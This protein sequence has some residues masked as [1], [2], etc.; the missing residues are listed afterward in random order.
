[1]VNKLAID[2]DDTQFE[3]A[4]AS[5]VFAKLR[6]KVPEIFPNLLGFQLVDR[7]ED[8]DKAFGVMGFSVGNKIALVP[9]I[10]RNGE[11]KA[12]DML[13]LPKDDTF[14]P[15]D[16]AWINAL[17]GRDPNQ[18]GDPSTESD[19]QFRPSSPDLMSFRRETLGK[20][21]N[22]WIKPAVP[23]LAA[24]LTKQASFTFRENIDATV[25]MQKLASDPWNAAVGRF[26]EIVPLDRIMVENPRSLQLSYDLSR[27]YPNIKKAFERFYG[28]DC[29]QRWVDEAQNRILEKESS[30]VDDFDLFDDVTSSFEKDAKPRIYIFE[31]TMISGYPE[32][33]TDDLERLK[34]ETI[35]IK[36]ERSPKNVSTVYSDSMNKQLQTPDAPGVYQVLQWD[37]KFKRMLVLSATKDKLGPGICDDN[38]QFRRVVIDLE[39]DTP[40]AYVTESPI[41]V[42]GST[43]PVPVSEMYDSL[44]TSR[45]LSTGSTYVAVTPTLSSTQ[46]FRVLEGDGSMYMVECLSPGT[47]YYGSPMRL[48]LN[49]EG[50]PGTMIRTLGDTLVVPANVA[51]IRVDKSYDDGNFGSLDDI[52]RL[53]YEKTSSLKL[54]NDH[55][56]YH[57]S[58]GGESRC[59]TKKGALLS[60]VG[61]HGLKEAD[62]RAVLRESENGR[63]VSYRIMHAPGFGPKVA[64]ANIDFT[65]LDPAGYENYGPRTSARIQDRGE[66][67]QVIESLRDAMSDQS[68]YD[69][70]ER[71][72][73]ED[74]QTTS[75]Q[76]S[77]AMQ[78]GQREI[79]DVTALK[80]MLKTV[81]PES[82][83]D[84]HLD[85][86]SAAVDSLA[87]LMLNFY[88]HSNEFE[89][90]YGSQDIPDIEDGLQNSFE[91]LGDIAIYLKNKTVETPYE[92]DEFSLEGIVEN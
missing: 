26:D 5:L 57:L 84:V 90:R 83:I 85:K 92:A 87:R 68:A 21:A 41:F 48:I 16:E 17:R 69:P 38:S 80:N 52:N 15:L 82:L 39:E 22:D 71:Y 27:M 29:F 66:D 30:V 62:A 47:S 14:F 72:Q 50:A 28:S 37:G 88:W 23:M 73:A 40:Q 79:F 9:A 70:W 46:M 44:P 34:K 32:L 18:I 77:K 11:I 42:D 45:E 2:G 4:F 3:Q 91:T 86:I 24:F 51:I 10:F 55:S 19:S 61:E 63:S 6:G 74:F 76:I 67:R 56:D 35:L 12:T 36:D 33:D 13:Y 60:L 54:V 7:T 1:M 75:Q 49:E 78:T 58:V 81:R 20:Y 31:Q 59:L 89:S 53:M 8:G 65:T 25:S 64:F 43:P